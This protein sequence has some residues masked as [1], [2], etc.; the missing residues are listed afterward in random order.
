MLLRFG[1]KVPMVG[2]NVRHMHPIDECL[3]EK[4]SAL[5][6]FFVMYILLCIY[7]LCDVFICACF[8]I[9]LCMECCLLI[10]WFIMFW[11]I[12]CIGF[13]FL[14]LKAWNINSKSVQEGEF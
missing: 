1:T 10:L 11:L 12:A 14:E 13:I 9:M 3:F 5:C 6:V 2:W 4:I 8:L 7:D